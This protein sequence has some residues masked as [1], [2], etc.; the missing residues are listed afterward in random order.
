MPELIIE[1]FGP[2]IC[3]FPARHELNVMA[4][5]E[6][7]RGGVSSQRGREGRRYLSGTS[8]STPT[9]HHKMFITHQ[10]CPSNIS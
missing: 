7:R 6:D 3:L 8:K 1:Q 5:E 9:P 4:S 10:R 2:K